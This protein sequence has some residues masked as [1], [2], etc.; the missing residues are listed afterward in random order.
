METS[1]NSISLKNRDVLQRGEKVC[2]DCGNGKLKPLNPDADFN[3]SFICD[4]CGSNTIITDKSVTV[5]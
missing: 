2:P 5:E 3:H 1:G 4:S